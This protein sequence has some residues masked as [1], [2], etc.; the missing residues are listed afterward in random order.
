[1]PA[2]DYLGKDQRRTKDDKPVEEKPIKGNVV[3][4]RI[5]IFIMWL[6][7]HIHFLAL[8]EAEIQL[9]KSYVR[10]RIYF[11]CSN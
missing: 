8:D 7:L 10:N 2:K 4:F 5:V 3:I 11:V 1:M 9:L 6:F